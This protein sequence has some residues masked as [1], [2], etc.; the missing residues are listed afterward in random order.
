MNQQLD[1]LI[2]S[3]LYVCRQRDNKQWSKLIH[4]CKTK[5][6]KEKGWVGDNQKGD[7]SMS[8]EDQIEKRDRREKRM[9]RK[10]NKKKQDSA[11]EMKRDTKDEI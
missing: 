8:K 11:A 3:E 9:I 5:G 1:K 4:I 7:F 6:W 2:T 10:K